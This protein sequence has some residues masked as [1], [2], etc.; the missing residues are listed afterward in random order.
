M[1]YALC[2][3][4]N[5]VTI[6]IVFNPNNQKSHG[7]FHKCFSDEKFRNVIELDFLSFYNAT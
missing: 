2:I 7:V 1:A 5:N 6:Q 3:Q 4:L